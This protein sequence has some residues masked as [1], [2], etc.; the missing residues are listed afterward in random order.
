MTADFVAFRQQPHHCSPEQ[1]SFRFEPAEVTWLPNVETP[2]PAEAN[3]SGISGGPCFRIVASENWIE[4]SGIIYEGD[5]SRG[6]VWA[7]HLRLISGRGRIS[8]VPL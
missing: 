6:G 4:L 1:V 8:P 2:L 5:Y 7:R 3:L